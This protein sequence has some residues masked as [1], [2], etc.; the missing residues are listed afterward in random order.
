MPIASGALGRPGI[1]A[2][3]GRVLAL[4]N[5]RLMFS[6]S[7]PRRN[8]ALGEGGRYAGAGDGTFRS[9]KFSTVNPRITGVTRD[10]TLAVLASCV[11][12][13]FRTVDDQILFESISDGAGDYELTALGS[14]PFYIVAYKAGSPDVM[15]TTV[16]TLSAD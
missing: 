16:N 13:L 1:L 2:I 4:G 15:G 10:S 6:S 7:A 3:P 5:G 14:G 8:G 12:Q 11:V 9:P